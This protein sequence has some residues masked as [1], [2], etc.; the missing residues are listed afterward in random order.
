MLE[1]I[2]KIRGETASRQQYCA[3]A[4]NTSVWVEASA[5][6]GKTK[7]LSDRVLRLLL[8]AD[9]PKPERILCLTYTKAG[10][11]EMKS[12]IFERLSEWSVINDSALQKSLTELFSGKNLSFEEMQKYMS[13]ARVLFALLLDTAGGMKIQTIH[14]FCQEIL[15]RFPIEAGVSPYFEVIETEE[16]IDILN[17]IRRDLLNN[18]QIYRQGENSAYMRYITENMKED[19]FDKALIEII[20]NRSKLQKIFDNYADFTDFETD[21]ARKIGADPNKLI[22]DFCNDFTKQ[23]SAQLLLA[24]EILSHGSKTDR[25][26]SEGLKNLSVHGW[27]VSDFENLKKLILTEK[28]TPQ[29]KGTKE[30]KLYNPRITDIGQDL[31]N[32]MSD[33]LQKIKKQKLFF[34]SQALFGIAYKLFDMYAEYKKKRAKLDYN[35]L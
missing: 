15:S 34:A 3:A 19:S 21:L 6:T 26:K 14:G 2:K 17:Q 12:R 24:A 1:D 32:K 33:T 10:A 20:E 16:Q 27:R 5:G 18:A 31:A 29:I 22:A 28:Q 9:N 7:V 23:N 35:D 25:E 13:R 8:N 11:V 4:P 30:S